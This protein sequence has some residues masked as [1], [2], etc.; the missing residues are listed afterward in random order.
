MLNDGTHH[1]AAL[2]HQ[3][4]QGRLDPDAR[5]QLTQG[6]QHAGDHGVAAVDVG[7]TRVA[8]AIDCIAGQGL[9]DAGE[10]AHRTEGAQEFI[11]LA[12]VDR[13]AAQQHQPRNRRAQQFEVA[14]Q[15]PAVEASGRQG[16]SLH[17]APHLAGVIVRPR[18][19]VEMNGRV[20]ADRRHSLGTGLE[21]GVDQVGAVVVT[22]FVAQEGAGVLDRVFGPGSLGLLGTRHP[23][24]APR[25]RA[26]ATDHP[27]LLAD[28]HIQAALAAEDGGRKA[29]CATAQNQQIG[30]VVPGCRAHDRDPPTWA[31]S[32]CWV[33][34][35]S[36]MPSSP[37]STPTPLKL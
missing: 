19:V 30:F 22:Q 37:P 8:Q 26:G 32:R 5:L 31:L 1:R 25:C 35:N 12:L 36:R 13:Q 14:P 20:P 4:N 29:G 16:A 24:E 17:H 23:D 3:F 28:Q 21:K 15:A 7:A 18:R 34:R 2:G 33:R 11:N 6:Q 10:G 27:R 9:H